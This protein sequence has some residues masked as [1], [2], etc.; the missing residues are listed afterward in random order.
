MAIAR[1]P[2]AKAAPAAAVKAAPVLTLVEPAAIA[3]N[4]QENFRKA[5]EQGMEQTRAAYARVKAEA[6]T[7]SG[8]IGTSF[9]AAREGI[10]SFN[11]M[12]FDAIQTHTR[13]NFDH[14]RALLNVK[15][16]KDIF[17][18]QS[19]FARKQFEAVSAQAKMFSSRLQKIAADA[20][21][22]LK[23]AVAAR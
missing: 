7:A 12:A 21:E 9:S 18:L 14:A 5:A 11:N 15:E 3:R 22:P 10:D 20:V 13:A 4:A 1:K 8:S 19:E 17:A 23:A 6:E 2:A 16:P